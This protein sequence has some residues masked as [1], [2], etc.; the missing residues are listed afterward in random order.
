MRVVLAHGLHIACVLVSMSV[1][2]LPNLSG[3]GGLTSKGWSINE[4]EE[5]LNPAPV[6]VEQILERFL[7]MNML[8]LLRRLGDVML[9]TGVAEKFS[10]ARCCIALATSLSLID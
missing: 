1:E 7:A 2:R 10:R 4:H 5:W 6:N 9:H 3:N 8:V